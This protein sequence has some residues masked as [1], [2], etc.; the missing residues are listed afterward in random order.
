MLQ[1]EVRIH[2][3]YTDTGQKT[4]KKPLHSR[5]QKAQGRTA[6]VWDAIWLAYCFWQDLS[7]TSGEKKF[8]AETKCGFRALSL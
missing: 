2:N 3:S 5:D 8:K 7:H 1:S 4:K 6:M